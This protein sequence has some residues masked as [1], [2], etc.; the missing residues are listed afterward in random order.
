MIS[1]IVCSR[2]SIL[3]EKFRSY[4]D[5][6]IGTVYEIILIDNSN[7]TFS[8]TKAYNLGIDKAVYNTLLFVHDDIEIYTSKFGVI[9]NT[10]FESDPRIGLIGI[11][12]AKYKSK[13]PST[14]SETYEDSKVINIIQVKDG[15]EIKYNQGFKSDA[16]QE[17]V[18]CIDGVFI[19]MN[20]NHNLRFNEK[21]LDF[22]NYDLSISM[23]CLK[24]KLKL[25]VTNEIVV[26][27]YSF[28]NIN[29]SWY[30]TSAKFYKT[31]QL[32]LPAKVTGYHCNQSRELINFTSFCSQL[33]DQKLYRLFFYFYFQ[34]IRLHRLNRSHLFLL[35]KLFG[36]AGYSNSIL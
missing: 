31:Y 34:Y 19:A 7:N 9:L 29:K 10:I 6:T 13:A 24:K 28:G 30:Q 20:K 5:N 12:G 25:I 17:E 1:V 2:S 36:F 8:L 11:A 26:K 23:E 22:H 32:N 15:K 18:V 4:L 21:I 16:K 33:I 3:S 35:K 14:W 27:H